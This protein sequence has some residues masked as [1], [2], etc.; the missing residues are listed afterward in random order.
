MDAQLTK[1]V[2]WSMFLP[3]PMLWLGGLVLVYCL[4]YLIDINSPRYF[5]TMLAISCKIWVALLFLF[6]FFYY[7]IAIALEFTIA[8][9]HDRV[10]GYQQIYKWLGARR[11]A[12]NESH[13]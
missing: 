8:H 10:I 1:P 3:Y 4:G 13:W 9:L 7:M 11:S 12:G 5:L 2:A 6:T